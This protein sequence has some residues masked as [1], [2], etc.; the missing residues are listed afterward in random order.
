MNL[1]RLE[2]DSFDQ[3]VQQMDDNG[4]RKLQMDEFIQNFTY[5]MYFL[6]NSSLQEHQDE[7]EEDQIYRNPVITVFDHFKSSLKVIQ[8][9]FSDTKS[10][11]EPNPPGSPIQIDEK[12]IKIEVFKKIHA[13]LQNFIHVK[14]EKRK[15]ELQTKKTG[16]ELNL[17]AKRNGNHYKNIETIINDE[18]EKENYKSELVLQRILE[19][20][21]V[22]CQNQLRNVWGETADTQL[23]CSPQNT[24][25]YTR[26]K[27]FLN[28]KQEPHT[29]TGILKNNTLV[30]M[31]SS[32]TQIKSQNKIPDLHLVPPKNKIHARRSSFLKSKTVQLDSN[33]NDLSG[34]RLCVPQ[35]DLSVKTDQP[36]MSISRK[37]LVMNEGSKLNRDVTF[38]DSNDN[39]DKVEDD[40]K[41]SNTISI[42]VNNNPC[43]PAMLTVPQITTAYT[44]SIGIEDLEDRVPTPKS[45]TSMSIQLSKDTPFNKKNHKIHKGKKSPT[46]IQKF[47]NNSF[48]KLLTYIKKNFK[49]SNEE[50]SYKKQL[51]DS[52]LIYSMNKVSMRIND[53]I[54]KEE[55]LM[56]DEFYDSSEL[57]SYID[58]LLKVKSLLD[59]LSTTADIMVNEAQKHINSIIDNQKN[60]EIKTQKDDMKKYE[61]LLKTIQTNQ[62]KPNVFRDKVNTKNIQVKKQSSCDFLP[63]FPRGHLRDGS[64]NKDKK[65]STNLNSKLNN[66][67]IECFSPI[68][69]RQK[70]STSEQQLR[71]KEKILQEL[72]AEKKTQQEQPFTITSRTITVAPLNI[73]HLKDITDRSIMDPSKCFEEIMNSNIAPVVAKSKSMHKNYLISNFSPVKKNAKQLGNV[74]ERFTDNTRVASKKNLI[75]QHFNQDKQD[76]KADDKKPDEKKVENNGYLLKSFNN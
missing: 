2:N 41:N 3:L 30:R 56:F 48:D 57:S 25:N 4:D 60:T 43:E 54:K 16:D 75:M 62:N 31:R 64:E 21:C 28:V 58:D 65:I 66:S 69:L 18:D 20:V 1:E 29:S 5:I 17:F 27:S 71:K 24:N 72:L 39:I 67:N 13:H 32:L 40:N 61:G 36:L 11:T 76:K 12:E 10:N 34:S 45:Y 59:N 49:D 50:Y 9:E 63:V 74:T 37:D 53:M 7:D 14:I 19:L 47:Q 52:N 8:K 23:S 33:I 46:K 26:H 35:S 73:S 51:D 55:V 68:K 15:A 42:Q 38:E 70:Y 22:N 44:D 6:I